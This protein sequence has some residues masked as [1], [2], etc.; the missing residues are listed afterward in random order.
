MATYLKRVTKKNILPVYLQIRGLYYKGNKV[1]CPCCGGRFSKFLKI[2]VNRRPVQC[3]RCRSN[4]RDRT[5]WL[6]LQRNPD[7][8]KANMKILHVSP[9][10]IFYRRFKNDKN[11][12][13]TACDKFTDNYKNTYPKDTIYMD[14]TDMSTIKD[15]TYDIILCVH[16]LECVEED[17]KAIKE[18]Y[19]VL[20]PGGKALLQ[21]P[22]DKNL[23][24]TY[25]DFSIN[26]PE[27]RAIIFGDPWNLRFYGLDYENLLRETAGFK[28]DF[29]PVT[30]IFTEK[31]IN[32]YVLGKMDD[33]Q[34]CYK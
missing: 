17:R 6:Y 12:S 19:R 2:G 18:L 21:V 8:I 29:I 33:I 32:K 24:K 7:F 23:E 1:E 16:V 3:P 25:E 11:I 26:T 9:E 4:E 5:F 34:L 10:Q 13:Y 28:T 27:Q 20:K 31:E 30:T 14:I 15:N 22:I